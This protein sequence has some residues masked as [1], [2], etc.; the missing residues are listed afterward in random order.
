MLVCR[1]VVDYDVDVPF[2]LVAS[3]YIVFFGTVRHYKPVSQPQQ[4]QSDTEAKHSEPASLPRN[5]RAKHAMRASLATMQS[6]TAS[7]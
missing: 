4:Q 3:H 6:D 7:P 2:P 1:R 5:Q